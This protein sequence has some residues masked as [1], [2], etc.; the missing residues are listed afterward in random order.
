MK[1]TKI[2]LSFYFAQLGPGELYQLS[3]RKALLVAIMPLI[4]RTLNVCLLQNPGS[5]LNGGLGFKP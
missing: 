1:P 5:Y 4:F 3:G 2:R